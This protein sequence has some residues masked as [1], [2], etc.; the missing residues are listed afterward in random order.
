MNVLAG[1]ILKKL[2]T[3]GMSLGQRRVYGWTSLH[4]FKVNW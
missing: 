2:L 4:N 3:L 1:K